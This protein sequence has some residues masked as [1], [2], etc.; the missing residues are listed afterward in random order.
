MG[1][2][3]CVCL[4]GEGVAFRNELLLQ[5]KVVFDNAVVDDH[6][7]AGAIAVG[8]GIFFGGASV[9][10]PA[11][12]ANPICALQRVLAERFFKVAKLAFSAADVQSL[13]T[14]SHRDTRGIVSAIFQ[15]P[16]TLDDD[17]NYLLATDI[18]DNPT[19]Y[20]IPRWPG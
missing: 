5:G 4:G 17:W 15:P 8:V 20:G 2:D 19:H 3:F 14:A 6:D 18:A 11:S 9:G 13:G 7:A 12:V 10:R 1:D 16:Q